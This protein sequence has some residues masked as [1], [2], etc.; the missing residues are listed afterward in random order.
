MAR[1]GRR[2]PLII[3]TRMIDRWWPA[4][5][6][7]AA[8]LFALAWA[9]SVRNPDPAYDWQWRTFAS[10]GAFVLIVSLFFIVIRKSAYIQPHPGHLRLVTPFLRLNISYKRLMRSTTATMGS[11]FPPRSIS[12]WRRDIVAPMAQETAIVIDLSGYPISQ[13]VL[14]FF[15]SPFFFKDRT[16]HFVFLVKDWMRF[17]TE[18]ESMRVGGAEGT[19]RP[20]RQE[21]DPSILARLPRK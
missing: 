5:L 17:S 15:L 12:S 18:L 2:Y 16:P 19:F 20:A 6:F 11:L 4:T 13:T 3:Y 7:L 1:A 14:R 8:G 10:V 9:L 21:S